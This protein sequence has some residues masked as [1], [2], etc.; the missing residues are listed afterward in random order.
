VTT[1]LFFAHHPFFQQISTQNSRE[2]LGARDPLDF[3]QVGHNM[4]VTPLPVHVRGQGLF[5]EYRID[6]IHVLCGRF[7]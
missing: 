6:E 3:V 1:F 4:I 7:H 5:T 2:P